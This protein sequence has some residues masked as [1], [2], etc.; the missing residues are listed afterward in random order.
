MELGKK[1]WNIVTSILVA[2]IVFMALFSVGA[3]MIGLQAFTVLSGSMEPAYPV[4]SLIY[5]KQVDHRKLQEGD[6]ITF[7][8]DENTVAT[9]RIVEVLTDGGDGMV[10]YRTKGDA[11][12]A[13]D[14]VAVHYKNVLGSPI[15]CIPCVGYLIHYI[16]SPPGMYIAIALGAVLLLLVVLPDLWKEGNA[17]KAPYKKIFRRFSK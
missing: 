17:E 5:V 15:W 9:H 16:Q 8:L 2:V 14:G 11:N 3:R 4:G 12:S 7:M 10:R 6:V 13:A 1:I